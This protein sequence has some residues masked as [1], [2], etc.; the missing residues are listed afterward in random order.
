MFRPEKAEC[1]GSNPSCVTRIPTL[2]PSEPAA[3]GKPDN[4]QK[5]NIEKLKLLFLRQTENQRQGK[6]DRNKLQRSIS[7]V[8]GKMRRRVN[9]NNAKWSDQRDADDVADPVTHRRRREIRCGQQSRRNHQA[10]ITNCNKSRSDN[11]DEHQ[12]D[13]IIH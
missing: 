9:A 12:Q 5:K 2:T 10:D 8:I 7:V 13:E 6:T 11:R 3:H 4:R 1:R